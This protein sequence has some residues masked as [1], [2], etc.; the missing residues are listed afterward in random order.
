MIPDPRPPCDALFWDKT[1][2]DYVACDSSETEAVTLSGLM[3][4][5]PAN[6]CKAHQK[7]IA[8]RPKEWAGTDILNANGKSISRYPNRGREA[9]PWRGR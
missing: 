2:A 3:F 9:A 1:D 6:L 8:N 5:V 7:Y 4:D